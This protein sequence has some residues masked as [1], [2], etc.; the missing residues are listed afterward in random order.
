[1]KEQWVNLVSRNGDI[2]TW[3]ATYVSKEDAEG[4]GAGLIGYL[5]AVKVP[6][7]KRKYW[8]N[9]WKHP[10]GTMTAGA[11][12]AEDGSVLAEGREI[13]NECVATLRFEA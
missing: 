12:Y 1:M 8:V 4:A 7:K 6:P 10:N 3:G 5:G 13:S 9:I 2:I 11:V